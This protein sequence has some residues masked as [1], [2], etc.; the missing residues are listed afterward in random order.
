MRR[1]LPNTSKAVRRVLL[2][3]TMLASAN[4]AFADGL[5]L[6]PARTLD[7]TLQ[8][9]TWMQPDLSPD[10]KTIVFNLL[11]DIYAIDSKG[12]DARPVLTGQAFETAPVYSPDGKSIAFVS[13]RS[14]VTNL[15]IA[16]TDGSNPRQVS[17]EDKL[18][19]FAT[20]VWAPDGS[21]VYVSRMKH[22]VLAFELWR[23][24]ID[25]SE[26]KA[27]VKAQP[28]GEDWDNRINA[29]G[30]AI[31]ADGRYA[32]YARK[33][34]HTWTE[35]APPAWSIARRDLKTDVEDV[36]I[37][38]QG[39]AMSPA[40]SH[41]GRFIAYASRWKNQ[42]GLRL[43]E[44]STGADRWLAFPIDHDG[45]EQGYY[46]GLTPRFTFTADDKA[47]IASVDGKLRRIE[48]ATGAATPIPFTVHAKVDLGPLTRVSQVEETG[49][50]R[51]RL[52]QAP[53]VSPDG[54]RFAFTALGGLYVQDLKPGS[55][56]AK[57][58][59]APTQAFQ[60]RWS[61]DGK[62]LVFVTW[63]PREGGAIW[64][65]PASGGKAVRL[66]TDGAFY[67]EPTFSPDG[68]SVVALKSSQYDRLR[69]ASEASPDWPTDIIRLPAAGGAQALVA[70]TSSA[71]L[72]SFGADPKRV[73]FYAGV[74]QSVALEGDDKP[75]AEFVGKARAWSQYVG[76]QTPVEE[77]KLSPAGD[78]AI[79]RTAAELFLV[80]VPTAADGKTPEVNLETA[81]S[82]VVKLTRIGADFFD[83]AEGGK[84]IVWS[85][86]S[87]LRKIAVA[88][89]DRT[90]SG[91]SEAKA[92]AV[93]ASVEVPRDTPDGT[94]VL[95]G[96]TVVTMRGDEVIQN[97]DVVV[98][99]GRIVSVGKAGAVPLSKG[100][101]VRDVAGK[102]ITPGFI[103]A[104]AHWFD[105]R[106]QVQDPQPWSFLVSL[107][108]GITSSLDP[109]TFTNDQ[110][111][112]Q[113]MADAGLTLAPRLYS[114]G[115]GVF[116]ASHID[117]QAQA[118]EVLKRYRDEYR[119]RNI[120]SYMVGD[121]A[122]R[123]YMVE[124]AKA[125]GMMPTT[126]GA[127]D[128]NLNLTHALDGFSGNEHA[129]PVSPLRED[130]VQLFAQ[131]RTSLVPTLN[132]LYGGEPPLFDLII[133]RRPQDEPRLKRFMPPGILSAKLGDR[134]WTPPE[135][136][137]YASFAKDALAIQRAG[138][139]VGLGSHSEV[140]GLG[141]AWEM[142]LFA[143]GG[144]TPLETIRAATMGS[145][146]AIGRIHDIGSLE[147]GKFA[148]LLIFDAD[149]L[150]DI[151]NVEKLGQ[152][153]KNGRLYEAA[154]LDEIWPRRRALPSQWF[155]GEA[156]NTN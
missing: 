147:P 45:Q 58:K 143:S 9:S 92:V 116:T 150:V 111:V 34:G 110:F 156:P 102:V 36:I 52:I 139:V 14:G 15:W 127:S 48:V 93:S 99:N 72:L 77:V 42:T 122:Q 155:Q 135:N 115:P 43:R 82:G 46:A 95:R 31:S 108:F 8:E 51:A 32:Y 112:Y 113:D 71:R 7:L 49:P 105:I 83:W 107:S 62:A 57:V 12:G 87:T 3:A 75:K 140:Q 142:Q 10:G 44:L 114:T 65:V 69:R 61:P 97:A 148:D 138:G 100:A 19:V 134:H 27:V 119:T 21:A 50:V 2:A 126:E 37:Q 106:R 1:T 38:G 68:M 123:Q 152:V 13:D 121:R 132:V 136:M 30:A 131:S 104:H 128:L 149:P 153:M 18:T 41:D 98:S 84:S 144:A 26:G 17:R 6:K 80:D 101:V 56:P 117:S 118:E 96:A 4:A 23:F 79:L 130:V 64:R 66:T 35:K 33:T 124:A 40:L 55:K 90:S 78:K 137:S 120:K 25:G 5:S 141:F 24:P 91:A 145:A 74:V 16:N 109:Q 28:N 29:M 67:T 88:D 154:T 47:L 22:P 63:D 86:G 89:I 53:S 20:P 85:V 60:P 73:R 103:D 81:T 39:G 70:H 146:E 11:G 54:K 129:L 94:M 59:N 76:V 125:L 151:A 133:T